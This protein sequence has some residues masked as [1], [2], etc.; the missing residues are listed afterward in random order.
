[1]TA[2]AL[3]KEAKPCCEHNNWD[4]VRVSKRV[5]TLRCRVCQKQWRAPVEAVWN[6]LK[7]AEYQEEGSCVEGCR[8]LHIN[9]RKQNLEARFQIHGESVIDQV[10]V[11]RGQHDVQQKVDTLRE[12]SRQ[13]RPHGSLLE[14]I[15]ALSNSSSSPPE[16]TLQVPPPPVMNMA[17]HNALARSMP[18]VL[19]PIAATP[20]PCLV[21]LPGQLPWGVYVQVNGL[22]TVG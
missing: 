7:C 12:I 10:R 9:Y 18:V 1:M 16:D 17:A 22:A 19:L 13:A 5:M 21:T 20:K 3:L 14:R 4:N 2:D 11:G 6:T 8:K 15:S